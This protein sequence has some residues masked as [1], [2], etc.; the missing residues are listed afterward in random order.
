[1]I[2]KLSSV[3][4]AG[5]HG[6]WGVWV[7]L[8]KGTSTLGCS[9]SLECL[10][11]DSGRG[12]T[13]DITG[14][15]GRHVLVLNCHV[16]DFA[17]PGNRQRGLGGA[18]WQ[19]LE[20]GAEASSDA[21][22]GVCSAGRAFSEHPEFVEDTL[23]DITAVSS[24]HRVSSNTVVASAL[25]FSKSGLSKVLGYTAEV[26]VLSEP[27]P[28]FCCHILGHFYPVLPGFLCFSPAIRSPSILHL[29]HHHPGEPAPN[30]ISVKM[31]YERN[32]GVTTLMPCAN[33]PWVCLKSFSCSVIF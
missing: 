29:V 20:P 14:N 4:G 6:E 9:H 30:C 19:D 13:M 16:W 11:G 23:R 31:R 32:P 8:H 21:G 18:A 15:V 3:S 7:M 17:F 10:F 1:M 12:V 5:F 24:L 28:L 22:T 33:R 25:L 26:W 2:F 27:R